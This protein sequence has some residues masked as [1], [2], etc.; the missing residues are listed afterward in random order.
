MTIKE[1]SYLSKRKEG[2]ITDLAILK[3][4]KESELHYWSKYQQAILNY[5][6]EEIDG[7]EYTLNL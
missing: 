6:E 7:I 5:V 4:L 2:L 1:K 3:E